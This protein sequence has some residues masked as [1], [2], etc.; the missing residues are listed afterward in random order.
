MSSYKMHQD[1]RHAYE[2]KYAHLYTA[3]YSHLAAFFRKFYSNF[4]SKR[5][6]LFRG[7]NPTVESDE[8]QFDSNYEGGNLDAAIRV[9]PG[10]Y[11]LFMRIDSNTRGHVQ[12]FNFTV[13]NGQHKK[14][15]LN[16]CNFRK[17]KTL[18]NR[19]MRPYVFSKHLK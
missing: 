10:E 17:E 8:V 16:I 9:A 12:W 18:F 6:R 4:Q 5:T 13:K 3:N 11:D 2:F 15:K 7:M 19:G 1:I 14:I